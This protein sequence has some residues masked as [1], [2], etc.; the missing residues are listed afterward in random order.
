M[1]NL[2][3]IEVFVRMA[4]NLDKMAGWLELRVAHCVQE[5]LRAAVRRSRV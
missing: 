1:R 4:H 2:R 3:I 5:K